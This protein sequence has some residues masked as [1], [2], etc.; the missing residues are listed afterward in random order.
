[1]IWA[2]LFFD[3]FIFC[4][5]LVRSNYGSSLA[6]WIFYLIGSLKIGLSIIALV[7]V[8]R[9]DFTLGVGISLGNL[10]VGC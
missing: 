8:G 2:L 9:G 10:G 6:L 3:S 1:M 7:M 5:S 4:L